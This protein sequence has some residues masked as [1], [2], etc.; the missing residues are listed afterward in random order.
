MAYTG[1]KYSSKV[2]SKTDEG[3]VKANNDMPT[4]TGNSRS[5]MHKDI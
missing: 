2:D 3:N 1:K 4:E 5:T